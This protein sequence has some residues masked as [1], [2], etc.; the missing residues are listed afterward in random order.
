M[1]AGRTVR[2]ERRRGRRRGRRAGLSVVLASRVPAGM[3]GA[4][5]P[6]D[7]RGDGGGDRW[8]GCVGFAYGHS[9]SAS[10]AE[11]G[12]R[13]RRA[14]SDPPPP[15]AMIGRLRRSRR[16]R[17]LWK[18]L[19]SHDPNLAWAGHRPM[20]RPCGFCDAAGAEV[21]PRLMVTATGTLG[22]DAPDGEGDP[23][24]RCHRGSARFGSHLAR[25]CSTHA[26]T[27]SAATPAAIGGGQ[28]AQAPATCL[29]ATFNR[30]HTLML[31]MARNTA[32][33]V[34]SS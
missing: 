13:E 32:A 28:G 31:A 2:S 20:S 23:L 33:S 22:L 24:S 26:C 25:A 16:R 27:P 9:C 14:D 3:L 15:G 7:G 5:L 12:Q 17:F 1:V 29:V 19:I 18:L 4:G 30:F 11:E 10:N 34:G 6:R 8:G 21:A